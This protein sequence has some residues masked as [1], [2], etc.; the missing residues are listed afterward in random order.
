MKAIV[1][2][3]GAALGAANMIVASTAGAN[4]ESERSIALV[5]DASGSMN[6][7]LPDRTTRIDA[8]KTGPDK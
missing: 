1:A 8:A 7:K 5:L 2:G 4:S 6:A 3:M